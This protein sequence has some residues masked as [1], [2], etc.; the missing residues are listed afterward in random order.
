MKAT[1][2]DRFWLV[3][4][5]PTLVFH[6]Q[7]FTG[8]KSEH[9][10]HEGMENLSSIKMKNISFKVIV[11]VCFNLNYLGILCSEKGCLLTASLHILVM[12]TAFQ[13]VEASLRLVLIWNIQGEYWTK[14]PSKLYL[15]FCGFCAHFPLSPGWVGCSPGTLKILLFLP[16]SP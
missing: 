4:V 13:A 11:F 7:N 10:F 2:L 8:C 9:G 6:A 16:R 1:L 14:D 15:I 5:P 12:L 3:R